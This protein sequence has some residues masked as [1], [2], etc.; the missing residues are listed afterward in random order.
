[1]VMTISGFGDTDSIMI[2]YPLFA[3]TNTRPALLACR[4]ISARPASE[5]PCTNI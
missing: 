5:R 2:R 1:M 4:V 3:V